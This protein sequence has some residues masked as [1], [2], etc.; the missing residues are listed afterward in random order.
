[1]VNSGQELIRL[2]Q[3]E[4]RYGRYHVL[5]VEGLSLKEGDRVLI[6][7]ANGS[8]KSTLLK[9]L[10]GIAPIDRGRM[11]RARILKTEALGYVP[12]TGGLYGQLSVQDNLLLRRRLYGRGNGRVEEAWYIKELGLL[13][14]LSRRFAELSGGFQRLATLAAALHVQPA[15]LLLDEPFGGVD[16]SKRQILLERLGEISRALRLHVIT[17]PAPEELPEV[18]KWIRLEEGQLICSEP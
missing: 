6:S 2:E 10:S 13:P 4:K 5:K 14:L 15:W 8:G 12:Q 11:W 7:G 3:V 1:M 17:V 9:V 18:N 16:P